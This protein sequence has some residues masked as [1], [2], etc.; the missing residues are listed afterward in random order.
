MNRN[1]SP[2]RPAWVANEIFPFESNFFTTPSGHAMHFID[3]GVGE[4]IVFLHGNPAWSFEFRHLV[5]DLRS[6]FRCIAPD[7]IGFGLS[8]RSN[9]PADYR[10]EAHANA[11]AA[12]LDHLDVQ[13]RD[14]LPDR[15]GRTDWIGFR[16]YASA[17]GQ[18]DCHYQHLVLAG[19]ARPPL[20][21]VQFFHVELAGQYLIK[22]HNFFVNRVLP[23]AVGQKKALTP[24]V[25]THY[26][27]A[28]PTPAARAACAALPGHIVG[29]SDWLRSIWDDRAAFS[30]KPA[31]I[32][33]GFKDIAFRKKELERWKAE[34]ADFEA[35]EFQDCGHFLAEEAPDRILPALRAFMQR[36]QS[37]AGRS[38]G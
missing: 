34:L 2:A 19:R 28:Q 16:A 21:H 8:S 3:E 4:P 31:L 24:E 5:K 35:H 6:R 13:G 7:H 23:M 18:A 32:F 25:M 15:L 37:R 30:G 36:T 10:P 22:R 33:W 27:N 20:C 29:T 26:R 11:V 1:A 14:P 12:L 38:S 17:A 9:Q